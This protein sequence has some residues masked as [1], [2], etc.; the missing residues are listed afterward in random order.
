ML[1]RV[2]LIFLSLISVIFT[3]CASIV[4]G[5]HQNISVQTTPVKGASCQ[6]T[7]KEGTW[8]IPSTPGS[9]TLNRAYSNLVVNCTKEE[10]NGAMTVTSKMKGIIFVGGIVGAAVD[11]GTGAAY[12]YPNLVTVNL[13]KNN[14]DA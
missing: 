1:Y 14:A 8:F 10:L 11:M 12:D 2:V 13:K 3:G 7:N 9:I 6:L 4:S 5:N